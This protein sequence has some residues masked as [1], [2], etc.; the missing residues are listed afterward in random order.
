MSGERDLTTLLSTMQPELKHG[1]YVFTTTTR[2]PVGCEPIALVR[3]EEGTT[4]VLQQDQADEYDLSYDFVAAMITLRVHS[5]LHAVGLTAAVAQTLAAA[6]ISCNV[7][8]GYHHDHLFVPVEK[9][10]QAMQLLLKR[11]QRG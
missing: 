9:G 3:E 8:A 2:V 10:E 11:A 6:G 7:V 1:R 5:S 4:L